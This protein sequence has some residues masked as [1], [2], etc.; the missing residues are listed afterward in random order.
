MAYIT[1]Q[2]SD[3][4]NT[5]LYTGNSST[6]AVTGVGFQPDFVWL[7]PRNL[8]DHH[9]AMDAVR[10]ASYFLSPNQTSAQSSTGSHFASFDSDGFTLG[11]S[12]GGWNNS[13][14]NY[15]TWNWNNSISS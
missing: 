4:F 14:Y 11:G 13:S 15:V 5:K 9:R 12:D 3:Y 10:T 8:A 6:N 7:K 1:F 2:P